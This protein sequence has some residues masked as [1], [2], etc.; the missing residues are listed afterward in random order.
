MAIEQNPALTDGC[1]DCECEHDYI[2]V[3]SREGS[4]PICG[5]EE[6]EQPDSHAHEA[7]KDPAL[8]MTAQE[9]M[10]SPDT[11]P[12]C[13][14]DP[15]D[16]EIDND[17]EG[18]CCK[19]ERVWKIERRFVGYSYTDEEGEYH[20]V[21]EEPGDR[22]ATLEERVRT[23]REAAAKVLDT[24]CGDP[25]DLLDEDDPLREGFDGLKA[26]LEATKEDQP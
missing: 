19:C 24:N 8:R 5:V 18:Y 3:R 20:E 22:I 9:A 1:W 7:A 21:T 4:C 14:A 15:M 12:F 2:H 26:A 11:C 6:D 10:E 13:H 23:L 25:W 16:V 17:G